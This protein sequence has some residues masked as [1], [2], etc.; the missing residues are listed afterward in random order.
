MSRVDPKIEMYHDNGLYAQTIATIGTIVTRV[1]I[2]T[3][4]FFIIDFLYT[5]YI[6]SIENLKLIYNKSTTEITKHHG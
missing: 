1:T 5:F 2:V 3:I 6:F 4:D